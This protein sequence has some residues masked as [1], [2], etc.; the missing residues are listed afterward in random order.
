MFSCGVDLDR[1]EQTSLKLR[2]CFC[3]CNFHEYWSKSM[4]RNLNTTYLV[5][6]LHLQNVHQ[7]SCNYKHAP[8]MTTLMS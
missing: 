5:S 2:A 4:E 6:P 3:L 7:C 1:Q 8:L